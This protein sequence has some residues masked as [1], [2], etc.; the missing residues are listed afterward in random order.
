[1]LPSESGCLSSGHLKMVSPLPSPV[2]S[3]STPQTLALWG[4][5]V[6]PTV[7]A[8]TPQ[9]YSVT[10]S[11]FSLFSFFTGC[12][13]LWPPML[14]LPS[15]L[16]QGGCG[17]RRPLWSVCSRGHS[18]LPGGISC[19][20]CSHVTLPCLPQPR[21]PQRLLF[22]LLPLWTLLCLGDGLQL[23]KYISLGVEST[24]LA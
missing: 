14:H 2:P 1:M 18:F 12:R 6:S 5:D 3:P 11:V 22:I 20:D 8:D 23:F 15:L 7:R 9:T 17:D 16:S 10:T 4:W 21:S 13:H 24:P 19:F